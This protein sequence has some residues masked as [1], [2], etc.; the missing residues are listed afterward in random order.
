AD[1]T[2]D[3]VTIILSNAQAQ[4]K[5]GDAAIANALQ[6]AVEGGR[7]KV[8]KAIRDHWNAQAAFTNAVD[9]GDATSVDELLSNGEKKAEIGDEA[10]QDGLK[11]AVNDPAKIAVVETILK[12]LTSA[13]IAQ[14]LQ[15]AVSQGEAKVVE[16]ILAKALDKIT[17]TA[18]QAAFNTAAG[19]DTTAPIVEALLSNA[20]AQE[21]VGDAAIAKAL[22]EALENNL[23]DVEKAIL[24]HWDVKT[25]FKKAVTDN[26]ETIIEDLLSN[27][28]TK[29]KVDNQ[30]IQA[31]LKEAANA[32]PA[33]KDVIE[34]ILANLTPEEI[35]QALQQARTNGEDKV[36]EA[37]LEGLVKDP[38]NTAAVL[39]SAK[40]ND[41]Q[42]AVTA[43]LDE[44]VK[45]PANTAAVL[46]SAK[47]QGKQDAAA[48]I[49][50]GL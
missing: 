35:A 46:D 2:S 27:A 30:T 38:A 6:K 26:N 29:A 11:K 28:K 1:A 17:A 19:D 25:A 10:I 31:G 43:I 50:E 33:K 7:G 47:K 16:V 36:V 14:A 20:Q 45:D 21:K 24:A 15:Q 48:A 4:E 5:V 40:K 32:E 42:D 18:L 13:E 8:E 9:K 22:K 34:T 37:I 23:P 3:I 12:N 44:L 39:D 49:L 41:K